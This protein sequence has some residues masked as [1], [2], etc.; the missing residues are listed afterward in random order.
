MRLVGNVKRMRTDPDG[1]VFFL[2]PCGHEVRAVWIDT[3]WFRG[4]EYRCDECRL[5]ERAAVWDDC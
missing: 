3:L 1:T 4:W 5:L 2:C